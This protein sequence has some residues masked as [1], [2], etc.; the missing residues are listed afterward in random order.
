MAVNPKRFQRLS[1]FYGLVG[2]LKVTD[3]APSPPAKDTLYKDNICK[4]RIKF[5]GTGT[6]RIYDSFNVS[7]ITDNGTGDY[8]VTWDL[9]FANTDYSCV[10]SA[11]MEH[12]VTDGSVGFHDYLVGSVQ[13]N[14]ESLAGA[15]I[16]AD[17]MTVHAFGGQ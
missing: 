1:D 6:I 13:V 12:G 2:G 3:P 9:D 17:L 15:A 11:I 5:D 14:V 10:G 4:A 7:S 16:N 8:Q